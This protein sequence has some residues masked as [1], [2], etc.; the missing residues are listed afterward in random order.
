[1]KITWSAHTRTE[2]H[3][4]N[5]RPDRAKG[6]IPQSRDRECYFIFS[7]SSCARTGGIVFSQLFNF[8]CRWKRRKMSLFAMRERKWLN[9]VLFVA[10]RIYW[11]NTDF[12]EILLTWVKGK[13]KAKRSTWVHCPNSFG[14]G[15]G[16]GS[17]ISRRVTGRKKYYER[18]R[19]RV[20][21][22]KIRPE[23]QAFKFYTKG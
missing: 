7:T 15:M 19:Q 13:K 11:K 2:T 9:P 8:P 10:D 14:R 21:S 23:N 16:R 18:E 22:P 17:R 5:A 20:V 3:V 6:S 1:M 12:R 4:P